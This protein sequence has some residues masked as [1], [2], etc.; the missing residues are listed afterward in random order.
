MAI[1]L[2]VDVAILRGDIKGCDLILF[3]GLFFIY[4]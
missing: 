4:D 2:C 3:V 1:Q